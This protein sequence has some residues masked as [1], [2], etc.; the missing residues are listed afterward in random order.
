MSVTVWATVGDWVGG[1]SCWSLTEVTEVDG[2][3]DAPVTV[4]MFSSHVDPADHR[5]PLAALPLRYP[6]LCSSFAPSLQTE[7][8]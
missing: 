3:L 2:L 4:R 1:H 8:M 5:A 7:P 6:H